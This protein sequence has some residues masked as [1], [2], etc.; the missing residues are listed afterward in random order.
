M[1][2]PDTPFG[3]RPYGH[4]YPINKHFAT[5]TTTTIQ[6]GDVVT[7]ATTGLVRRCV[8]TTGAD[9]I[10]GVASTAVKAN[11]SSQ[12]V[13]VHDHPDQLFTIQD[14]GVAATPARTNVGNTAPLVLGAGNTTT[15]QSIM[16]LDISAAATGTADPLKILGFVSGPGLSIGKNA[17]LIV[18]LNKHW[19]SGYRSAV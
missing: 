7:M 8:T 12:D 18:K 9:G 2:N 15:Q 17:R 16:E 13:W 14:D 4:I 19:K 6:I 10:V 3:L 11:L 1:P 5:T